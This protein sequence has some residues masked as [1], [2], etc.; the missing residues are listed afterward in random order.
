[1]D[2]A[3]VKK[4][5]DPFFTTK[6][7]GRGLGLA[8]AQG[9][10]RSHGGTIDV[11]SVA[12]SHTSIRVSF[13]VSTQTEAEE[14]LT[15]KAD[16]ELWQGLGTILLA[17]DDPM[18]C[19]VA[20]R[21]LEDMGFAVAAESDGQAA[22]GRFSKEPDRFVAV[23]SD[24]TM[25]RM[26]GFQALHAMREIRPNLPAVLCS[27]YSERVDELGQF[28]SER[29]IFLNKP[30][31]SLTLQQSL[32]DLLSN[33]PSADAQGAVAAVPNESE[34]RKQSLRNRLER[35]GGAAPS[36]L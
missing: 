18:V 12:G 36:T 24:L 31:R 11:D 6:F 3:T 15:T 27:G 25:P 1:M 2:Q 9:V 20:Q 35:F 21:M 19:A 7:T 10:V 8:A 28:D 33:D 34:V 26:D 30:F 4:I 13:P 16:L 14:N 22:L 5:F 32:H 23:V 17:E 29:T